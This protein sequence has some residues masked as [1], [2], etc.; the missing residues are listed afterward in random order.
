MNKWELLT[1]GAVVVLTGSDGDD[2]AKA[3]LIAAAPEMYN[4]LKRFAEC[5]HEDDM[6]DIMENAQELIARI[7]NTEGTYAKADMDR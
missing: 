7:D 5:R 1:G 4:L 6:F 3:R 2:T